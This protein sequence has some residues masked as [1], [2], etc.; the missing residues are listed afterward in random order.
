MTDYLEY[1]RKVDPINQMIPL[2]GIPLSGLHCNTKAFIGLLR[3]SKYFLELSY[4]L[5]LSNLINSKRN[6]FKNAS[7]TFYLASLVYLDC[8]K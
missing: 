5:I 6:I 3:A 1:L 4:I 8:N 7:N 2:S